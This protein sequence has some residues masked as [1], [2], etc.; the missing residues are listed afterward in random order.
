M[1]GLPE[2]LLARYDEREA[3]ARAAKGGRWDGGYQYAGVSEDDYQQ[4]V[5]STDEYRTVAVFETAPDDEDLAHIVANQPEAVLADL[6]RK[7][8]IVALWPDN[9]GVELFSYRGDLDE[10]NGEKMM[11]WR[12]LLALAQEFADRPD[13]DERWR[14]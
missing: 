2:Y 8:A 7:R 13:F 4:F 12:V 9:D 10:G 14:A 11:H 5:L 1:S 3:L 6:A